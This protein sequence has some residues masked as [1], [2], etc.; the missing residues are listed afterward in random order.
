MFRVNR[1]SILRW[2]AFSFILLQGVL[3]FSNLFIMS[4]T[5]N[6]IMFIMNYVIG[7]FIIADLIVDGIA[8]HLLAISFFGCFMLFLMAQKPFKPDYDVFLTFAWTKLDTSQYVTFSSILF[9]GLAVT[10]LSYLFFACRVTGIKKREVVNKRDYYQALR[11]LVLVLLILTFPCALYMQA[12]VVLVR[13]GMS[14]TSGYLVNVDVPAVVKVGYYIYSGVILVFLVLKPT[15]KQ[16]WIV[17]GTYLLVEGGLQLL[18]GRRAL[19]ASTLLFSI[20]YLLKYYNIKKISP[21]LLF[22]IGIIAFGLVVLFF[23]VEQMR[24]EKGFVLSSNFIERFLVSTGGSDSVIA[25]TIARK[26][27]FPENGF[28]YLLDPISNNIIGNLILRKGSVAQGLEYLEL[29]NSFA[30]WLSYLTESSLYLSGHGM[31]SCYLAEMYLAMGM[32]GVFLI[33]IV[34]G[35]VLHILDINIFHLRFYQAVLVLFFIRRVF[36]LPRDGLLSWIGNLIYLLCVF[37]LLLPFY[38]IYNTINKDY[39]RDEDM[40]KDQ[41]YGTT[42]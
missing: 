23:V 26:D 36:T 29:H 22:R 27:K 31:G 33:S 13:S 9:C 40:I 16:L 25:N 14:Y 24:D 1:N 12:K 41:S 17:L 37:A 32:V 39:A 20:W 28:K 19:F 11:P 35:L 30:H 10:Y 7:F 8:Q 18:Q 3:I 4:D 34:L 42:T 2:I 6:H 15:K 21:K 5:I 38:Y